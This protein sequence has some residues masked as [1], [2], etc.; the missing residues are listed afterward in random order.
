[1]LW[2]CTQ[3]HW[4]WAPPSPAPLALVGPSAFQVPSGLLFCNQPYVPVRAI[5]DFYS[6]RSERETK[7]KTQPETLVP[8]RQSHQIG[9]KTSHRAQ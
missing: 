1:M 5:F 7:E 9:Y 4:S 2:P 3:W 6:E 8:L